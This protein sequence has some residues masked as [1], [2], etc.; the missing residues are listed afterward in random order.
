MAMYC[1]DS[2]KKKKTVKWHT[3][4][5]SV[6]KLLLTM[7]GVLTLCKVNF[8]LSDD[9]STSKMTI[10]ELWRSC[11]YKLS[12]LF[13]RLINCNEGHRGRRSHKFSHYCII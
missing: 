11:T 10:L 2:Y 4:L 8:K 1:F 9:K 3:I 6:Y 5:Y 13:L 7:C 12:F